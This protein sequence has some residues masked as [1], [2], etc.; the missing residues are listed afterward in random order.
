MSSKIDN[1]HIKVDKQRRIKKMR[2]YLLITFTIISIGILIPC[3]G[4]AADISLGATTWY[5]W[6]DQYYTQ[7]NSDFV[8]KSDPALFYGPAASVKFNNDFNLTFV[9]LYGKFDAAERSV[10]GNMKYKFKR[11]DSDLAIN[12]RLDDY[13]KIFF[14]LK[15]AGFSFSALDR[16]NSF[17][18]NMKHNG[19][20]PGLGLSSTFPLTE[21]IF[22][23]ANLSGFYLWG[24]E[25]KDVNLIPWTNKKSDCNDYGINSTISVAYYI[26]PASTVISLG[27]RFQYVKTNYP[28]D[29]GVDDAKNKFYGVTL[30][31]TY[32]F[33]I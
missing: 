16:I 3:K 22:I 5:A 28:S 15:Y 30:T 7:T 23:L 32:S 4:Y 20:G 19:F 14:G 25:S 26:A 9:Y 11:R 24:K 6:I 18:D 31:A 2:K 10:S 12:Y 8:I 33:S 29:Y 21:N 27:G 17:V 13:F 1:W